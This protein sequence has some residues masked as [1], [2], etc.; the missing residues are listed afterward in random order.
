M[1]VTKKVLLSDIVN[2]IFRFSEKE[3]IRNDNNPNPQQGQPYPSNNLRNKYGLD[4]GDV[5][6]VIDM[7][8]GSFMLTPRLSKINRLGERVSKVLD[9]EG[10]SLDDLL[11]N[12][13]E[14]RENY[15]HDYYSKI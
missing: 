15:Y 9:S 8:D 1:K 4:E 7:G 6:T 5:F 11:T 3:N 13:D 12:L 2:Q 14:E 10:L